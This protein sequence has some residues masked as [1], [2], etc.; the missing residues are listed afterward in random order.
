MPQVTELR[1]EFSDPDE[2]SSAFGNWSLVKPGN[3]EC[4]PYPKFEI[5]WIDV[6]QHDTL[7]I[8]LKLKKE[9]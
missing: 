2:A 7:V 6:E 5:D 8:W 4:V 9:E 1:Y 3:V